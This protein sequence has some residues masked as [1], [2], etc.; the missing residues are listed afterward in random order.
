MM[1]LCPHVNSSLDN[2][3]SDYS[4]FAFA[5]GVCSIQHVDSVVFFFY[6]LM[7]WE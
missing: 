5:Q 6:L 4:A 7:I 3:L 2:I 1:P